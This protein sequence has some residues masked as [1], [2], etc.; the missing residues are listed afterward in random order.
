MILLS[1]EN[2]K[3]KAC[4]GTECK[5]KYISLYGPHFN[6]KLFDF[7]IK[8][9]YIKE[10]D[11]KTKLE[12]YPDNFITALLDQYGVSYKDKCLYDA[13]Y[14]ANMCKADFFGSSISDDYHLALYVKDVIED[15]DA[16]EGTVFYRWCSD[17]EHAGIE[18]PWEEFL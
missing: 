12:P 1:F 6:K 2:C 15:V 9:M 14:V 11:D 5:E 10:G 17:M 8:H 18:I 16:L 3:E 7:A 4:A 13:L